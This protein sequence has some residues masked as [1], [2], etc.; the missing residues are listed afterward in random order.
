LGTIKRR[1]FL[2]KGRVIP[3]DRLEGTLPGGVGKWQA[4]RKR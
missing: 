4:E 3:G 1:A 2:K